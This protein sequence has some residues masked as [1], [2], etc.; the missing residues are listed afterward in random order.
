MCSSTLSRTALFACIFPRGGSIHTFLDLNFHIWYENETVWL[1]PM[2]QEDERSCCHFE[3][4][5][6]N[7]HNRNHFETK[8]WDKVDKV[9]SQL[10][11]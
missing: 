7:L 5:D 4:R 2:R 1:K 9:I 10:N 3:S 8:L 11:M 6:C